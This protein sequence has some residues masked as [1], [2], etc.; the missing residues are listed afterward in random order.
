[1]S[2]NLSRRLKLHHLRAVDA[3]ARYKS[4]LQASHVLCVSQPALSK[5]IREVEDAVGVTLFERH[6]KGLRPN[7]FGTLVEEAA[8]RIIAELAHLDA[9]LDIQLRP[10]SGLLNIGALPT[11]AVGFLPGLLVALRTAMPQLSINVIQG[12]TE[13]MLSAV[14]S[15]KVDL[16]L[17]RLYET[18]GSDLFVREPLYD[19]PIS[20]LAHDGHPLLAQSH[21][22][23]RDIVEYGLVLPSVTQR[24]GREIEE[25]LAGM[26]LSAP[27]ASLRSN[28]LGLVRELI[29][30][31]DMLA[32]MPRLMMAG[33]L[34]RG[35]IQLLPLPAK[36]PSRPAGITY[37]A[38]RPRTPIVDAFVA[39]ARNYVER[40]RGTVLP[41]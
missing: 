6:A 25:A 5:S 9:Q 13:Q 32:A 36:A 2:R 27:E 1:M 21:V 34:V 35:T 16:V 24:V 19:E 14:L 26:K 40:L 3:V 20:L 4:V 41:L 10:T 15:G 8:Q 17:G 12:A 22:R 28:S 23:Q 7:R 39:F 33:D 29:L 31:T 30:T 37:A 38:G 18:D 11:T